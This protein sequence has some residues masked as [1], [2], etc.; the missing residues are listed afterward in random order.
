VEASSTPRQVEANPKPQ[1]DV[2]DYPDELHEALGHAHGSD[3]VV[4]AAMSPEPESHVLTAAPAA[5]GDFL[6][7]GDH[8]GLHI[9]HRPL[10]NAGPFAGGGNKWVWHITVSSWNTVDAMFDVLKA[11]RAAP[12]LIIGGRAGVARPVVIQCIPFSLA[13]RALE[14]PSGPETNRAN[15][16]Q[17]EICATVADVAEFTEE[18]YKAFANLVRLTNRTVPPSRRVPRVLARPFRNTARFGGQAFFDA[19]GHC[20][21]MHVPLNSHSDPTTGFKGSHILTLLENMPDGG[22]RL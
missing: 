6:P 19:E 1:L 9:E 22:H 10:E 3:D 15:A 12:H 20:G 5:T 11:K 18:K 4:F 7:K 21:H 13:G 16:I 8:F 17:V 14:H 2:A